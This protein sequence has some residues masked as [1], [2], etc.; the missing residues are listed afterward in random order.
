MVPG[1]HRLGILL[2]S[3]HIRAPDMLLLHG[4]QVHL[5]QE[6]G[7]YL[8]CTL[9]NTPQLTICHQIL[10]YDCLQAN[11]MSTSSKTNNLICSF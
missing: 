6:L 11:H 5:Q 10:L 9:V 7:S 1:L 8:G 3:V 4:L 2:P